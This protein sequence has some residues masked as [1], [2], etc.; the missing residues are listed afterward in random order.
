MN[1]D[2]YIRPIENDDLSDC[3]RDCFDQFGGVGS[4]CKGNVYI[5]F[6]GTGP[7]PEIMTDTEVILSTVKVV[8][9]TINPDNIYVMEK[10]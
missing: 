5:K 2:V 4:I 6:N 3:V 10:N 7:I 1:S 8:K 9:E